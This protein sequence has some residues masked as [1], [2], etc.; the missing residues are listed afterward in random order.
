[1]AILELSLMLD[2]MLGGSSC[3]YVLQDSDPLHTAS[4]GVSQVIRHEYWYRVT[5]WCD[6]VK[7]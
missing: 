7:L 5:I 6:L 2:L 4:S 1:M 3:S